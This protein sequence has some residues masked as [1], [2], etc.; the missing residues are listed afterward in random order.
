[1]TTKK[2]PRLDFSVIIP[3]YNRANYL[4]IAIASVLRQKKVHFEIIIGDDCSTD[5]TKQVVQSFRD[6]RI[7]LISNMVRLGSSMNMQQCFMLSQGKY[8][9]TLGDDDFILDEYALV[10]IFE[11]METNNLGIGKTGVFG[12]EKSPLKPY[13]LFALSDKQLILKPHDHPHILTDSID[14]GLGYYSGLIFNNVLMNKKLLEMNHT[15]F[16]D[17]M[18]LFYHAAAYTLINTHGIGYIPNHFVVGRLS[19]DLI[20]RYFDMKRHGRLFIEEPIKLARKCLSDTEYIRFKKMYIRKNAVLL[21]NIKYYTNNQNYWH[22]LK[23]LIFL[24]TS[25]FGDAWFVLFALIGLMP[26]F[27][28]QTIRLM[29]IYFSRNVIASVMETSQYAKNVGGLIK[30]IDILL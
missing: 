1:M 14:F 21:P 27:I 18:C 5:T 7:R 3:T 9:F 28:I 23:R 2:R 20:P 8:I 10:D 13:Q 25:L 15:C 22:V 6:N 19:L 12:Y 30:Y 24:D 4:R 17:H 11:M 29:K 16:A 26:K